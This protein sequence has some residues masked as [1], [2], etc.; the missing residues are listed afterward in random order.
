LKNFSFIFFIII[1]AVTSSYS[2]SGFKRQFKLP[3]ALN[4]TTKAVFETMPNNYVM[5]GIV[6]DTLNGFTTNRLTLVGLN[7]LGQPQWTKKYGNHKF[8]Y[9]DNIFISKWF[10]KQGNYLYHAGCVRDSNNLQLGV[11]I[12]FNFNGD[13]IWQKRF[14]EAGYDVIP[15][16]V[17]GSIDGGFLITGWFQNLTTR[18]VLIIK[19]DANGNEL[20]RKKLNKA[21]PNTQDAKGIV[22]DTTTKKIVTIGYQYI[23]SS[24][25][26]GLYSNIIIADSLGNKLQQLNPIGYEGELRDIIQTKDKKFV[27]VGYVKNTLMIGAL[28]TY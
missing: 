5:C 20:W 4:N 25:A 16:Q 3:Y 9:L 11:F 14:Y 2:Q 15:Q 10:Y 21:I 22:Q 8:E 7:A 6:V 19:T 17:V 24:S 26:W 12:K 23:G 1:F 18:P 13:T 28:E 27:A